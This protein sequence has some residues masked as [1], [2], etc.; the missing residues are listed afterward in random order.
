VNHALK[1]SRSGAGEGNEEQYDDDADFPSEKKCDNSIILSQTSIDYKSYDTELIGA[2]IIESDKDVKSEIDLFI[3]M[4]DMVKLCPLDIQSRIEKSLIQ[5]DQD[6]VKIKER[7]KQNHLLQVSL[8]DLEW[9]IR[10]LVRNRMSVEEVTSL[11]S[12]TNLKFNHAGSSSTYDPTHLS[13]Q[14]VYI[15][16]Y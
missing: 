7:M 14:K 15:Y 13:S 8:S 2:K 12:A 1:H 10:M 5:I 11:L 16:I 4:L 3:E 6:R 9:K